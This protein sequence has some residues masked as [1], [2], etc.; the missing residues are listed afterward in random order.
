M[1]KNWVLGRGFKLKQY[2]G[3]MESFEIWDR[4]Y[5]IVRNKKGTY[6]IKDKV[7]P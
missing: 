2:M 5:I 4:L 1:L 6:F 3:K 7:Y